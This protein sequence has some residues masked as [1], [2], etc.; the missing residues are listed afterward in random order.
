MKTKLKV[1]SPEN[2]ID[3]NEKNELVEFLFK[4][5]DEFGDAEEHIKK[6]ADYAMNKNKTYGGKILL[7]Y[8][9][10][11]L[12][13]AV[14]LNKTGMAGYIPENILVY[15]AI[16][17]DY[18]GKGLGKYLMKE[19]IKRSS[20]N[21]ALHVEEDNPAKFLYEKLGFKNKYLEMRLNKGK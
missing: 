9:N 12:I 18:R 1:F 14:I 15:I 19:A 11:L 16:H 7:L 3:S 20:G 2:K 5:L 8:D 21:I 13:G 17:K 6:S 4:H 10:K